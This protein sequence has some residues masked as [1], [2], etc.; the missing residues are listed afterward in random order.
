MPNDVSFEYVSGDADPVT[1][2]PLG[3]QIGLTAQ[4]HVDQIR[5]VMRRI[6]GSSRMFRSR[7]FRHWG[8]VA[9]SR[10]PVLPLPLWL[11][12]IPVRVRP[13]N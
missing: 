1:P 7:V 12:P 8:I 11:R 4:Q 6:F 2:E 13:A 3:E 9:K 10:S 5:I